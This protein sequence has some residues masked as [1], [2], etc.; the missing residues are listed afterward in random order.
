MLLRIV[1]SPLQAVQESQKAKAGAES[2]GN[3]VQEMLSMLEDI[4]HL[5][6]KRQPYFLLGLKALVSLMN[7]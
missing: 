2:T 7:S 6:G 4:L 3:A 1:L 5:M